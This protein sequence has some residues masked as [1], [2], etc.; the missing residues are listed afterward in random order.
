[1]RPQPLY[2]ERFDGFVLTRFDGRKVR[3]ANGEAT[4]A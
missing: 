3:I 4:P 2:N 1:V